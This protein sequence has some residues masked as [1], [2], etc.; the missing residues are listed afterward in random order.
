VAEIQ[1]PLAE[2]LRRIGIGDPMW[3]AVARRFWRLQVLD[4]SWGH[5]SELKL[6]RSRKGFSDFS[7][8]CRPGP[9]LRHE[10]CA[11][12]RRFVPPLSCGAIPVT[13]A[14]RRHCR[15]WPSSGRSY[16]GVAGQQIA[17]GTLY[18]FNPHSTR[19]K[20]RAIRARRYQYLYNYKA[21]S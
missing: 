4:S 21:G 9:A 3:P 19:A 15:V 11:S 1:P 17:P 2:E 12:P 14:A 20:A 16:S 5:S 8:R 7:G 18:W 13:S 6:M 10:F